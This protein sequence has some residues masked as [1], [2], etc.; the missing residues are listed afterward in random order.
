VTKLGLRF[1]TFLR[2]PLKVG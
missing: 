2:R 1:G